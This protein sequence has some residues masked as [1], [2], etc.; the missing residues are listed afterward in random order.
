MLTEHVSSRP[1]RDVGV[2][3]ESFQILANR[4]SYT[5]LLL[6]NNKESWTGV[7]V[8]WTLATGQRCCLTEA[9]KLNCSSSAGSKCFPLKGSVGCTL[10]LSIDTSL[11]WPAAHQRCQQNSVKCR[12]HL[13]VLIH[14]GPHDPVRLG[15]GSQLFGSSVGTETLTFHDYSK[16]VRNGIHSDERD[17]V[18]NVAMV[19][20]LCWDIRM[21]GVVGNHWTLGYCSK[22]EFVRPLKWLISFLLQFGFRG[23]L[24]LQLQSLHKV[25]ACL[26]SPSWFLWNSE[27]MMYSMGW[28]LMQ[29]GEKSPILLARHW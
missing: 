17:W 16:V 19:N 28:S 23:L 9:L 29:A 2:K 24:K 7:S 12:F 22:D 15:V 14:I 8:W 27:W 3:Q 4:L 26:V 25:S 11:T 6:D 10:F 18:L 1:A 20:D 21:A 13:Q 5:P